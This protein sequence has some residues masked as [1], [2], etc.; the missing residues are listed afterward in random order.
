MS[1]RYSRRVSQCDVFFVQH[2][3]VRSTKSHFLLVLNPD[4]A[5]SELIVFGVITSDIEKAKKRIAVMKE[6]EDTLVFI[7]PV[8]YPLLDHDSVID[9]N[10][11]VKYSKWEFESNFGQLNAKRKASMPQTVVNAVIQGVLMSNQVPERLKK[12]LH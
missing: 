12:Q 8:D 9:C 7:S 5:S 3:E 6:A 1:A 10:T 4:P 11:P 2:R